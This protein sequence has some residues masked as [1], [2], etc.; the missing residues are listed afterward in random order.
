MNAAIGTCTC[1]PP[2]DR[3]RHRARFGRCTVPGCPCLFAPTPAAERATAEVQTAAFN[4]LTEGISQAQIV[5]CFSV[6]GE[7]AAK[8][9]PRFDTRNGRTYTPT[10]TADAERRVV[11]YLKV[12]YPSLEPCSEPVGLRLRLYLKGVGRGDADNYLKLVSDALNTVAYRDDK[13]VRKAE[14]QLIDN[15]RQPRSDVLVYRLGAR[16]L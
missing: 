13:Q 6:Q 1:N 5:C 7:P 4:A 10:A 15:N 12:L 9:R 14:V 3:N 11:Q 2:H 16:L 8:M